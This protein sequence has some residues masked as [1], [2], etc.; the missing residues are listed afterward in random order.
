M[1]RLAPGTR[2]GYAV[3]IETPSAADILDVADEI[4]R[5]TD[6]FIGELHDGDLLDASLD[7]KSSQPIR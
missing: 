2:G 5:V 1:E 3:R 6:E 7:Q 4:E